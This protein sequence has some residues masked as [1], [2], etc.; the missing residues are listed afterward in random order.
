MGRL[1]GEEFAV[2][3]LLDGASLAPA[4][5]Q[6]R[7]HC[8]SLTYAIGAPP[9]SVSAGIHHDVPD[10]LDNVLHQAD[11]RLYQAKHQGRGHWQ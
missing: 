8:A 6:L 7:E 4:L 10:E 3:S 11:L 2:V 5:V 1:A 9:L